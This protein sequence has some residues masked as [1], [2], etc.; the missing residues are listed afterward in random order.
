MYYW[1]SSINSLQVLALPPVHC[2]LSPK[3]NFILNGHD[4]V[5]KTNDL[6]SRK[7]SW[8]KETF[9]T[10]IC[11][12]LAENLKCFWFLIKYYSTAHGG[13]ASR[14]NK[15]QQIK[16]TK[17]QLY[18]CIVAAPVM[19]PALICWW[20]KFPEE[21]YHRFHIFRI[22]GSTRWRSIGT[23]D[24]PN[25]RWPPFSSDCLFLFCISKYLLPLVSSSWNEYSCTPQAMQR[26]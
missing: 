17:G 25:H 10:N 14:Y 20:F 24:I 11:F 21:F 1:S 18:V 5:F 22:L 23:C 16:S 2:D 8:K 15:V 19:T 26:E 9:L 4:G 7:N 6:P 3:P 12:V 13:N